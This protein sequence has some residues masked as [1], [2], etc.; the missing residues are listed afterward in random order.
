M[1]MPQAGNPCYTCSHE[2]ECLNTVKHNLPLQA[3][4]ITQVDGGVRYVCKACLRDVKNNW[5]RALPANLLLG[6]MEQPEIQRL[7]GMGIW[8]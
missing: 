7:S 1:A 4:A 6:E 2:S 3:Q 8:H 5:R